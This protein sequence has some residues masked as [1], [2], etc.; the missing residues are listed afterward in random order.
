MLRAVRR[1]IPVSVKRKILTALHMAVGKPVVAAMRDRSH[2]LEQVLDQ[3]IARLEAR[4][5]VTEE[6]VEAVKARRDAVTA[7]FRKDILAR[8]DLLISILEQRLINLERQLEEALAKNTTP[9]APSPAPDMR[10]TET[11]Q[12]ELKI[13]S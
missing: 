1:A 7:D 12:F 6:G 9:D 3:R 8:Q 11:K 5:Q 2:A 4:V 10:A 13:V